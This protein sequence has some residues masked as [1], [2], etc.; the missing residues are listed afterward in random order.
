VKEC[1]YFLD[2]TPTHSYMKALYKY[3]QAAYP[4]ERLVDENRRRGKQ[5]REFELIDTGIFDESRY[6][7]VF[8]EYAK[9]GPD[10][11]L[12]RITVANRGPEAARLHV[13]PTLWARNTW[14]WKATTEGSWARPRFT[15]GSDG[16]IEANHESLGRYRLDFL[17]ARDVLFTENETNTR[18]LFGIDPASPHVKD[19]FHEYVVH[20]TRA[21]STRA[22]RD[23][24]G[25]AVRPGRARAR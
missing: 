19:A 4:Y 21:R 2:S 20:G 12:I 6:F 10:D 7:D 3:P 25:T 15:L 22:R 16:A 13:V 8:V 11:V 9:G 14:S 5:D 23:E 17:P 18:R 1:Y 24:G